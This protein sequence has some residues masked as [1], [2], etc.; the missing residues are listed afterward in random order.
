MWAHQIAPAQSIPNNVW[1]TLRLDTEIFDSLGELDL[2]TDTFTATRTG[3]YY[4]RGMVSFQCAVLASTRSVAIWSNVNV[5]CQAVWQPTVLFQTQTVEVTGIIRLVR[6]DIVRIRIW[7]GSGFA[8]NLIQP[9]VEDYLN[10]LM[11]HRLS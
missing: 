9:G 7:Q 11:I 5:V 8:E 1:T 2:A 10:V 3:Y 6:G 4:I